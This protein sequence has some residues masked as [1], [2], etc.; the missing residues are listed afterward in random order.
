MAADGAYRFASVGNIRAG[1]N[2]L[3][4][5]FPDARK[6][7]FYDE[8]LGAIDLRSIEISCASD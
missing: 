6:P 3:S 1:A 8:R 7:N 4:F 2:Q 5:R